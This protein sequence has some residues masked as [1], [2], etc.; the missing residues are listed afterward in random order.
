MSLIEL[1]LARVG[2]PSLPEVGCAAWSF[3]APWRRPIRAE[4][5]SPIDF[6]AL[7]SAQIGLSDE[8]PRKCRGAG[9][10]SLQHTCARAVMR[11]R[12]GSGLE[13]SSS[14]IAECRNYFVEGVR[15]RDNRV[16][17]APGRKDVGLNGGKATSC[18]CIIAC[19]V[20]SF[21]RSFRCAG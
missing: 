16:G 19:I 21:R 5:G 7:R 1:R 8:F 4:R 3:A 15:S 12:K 18:L 11:L 6:F 10:D 17:R 13:R 2:G 14:G 20:T 9:V